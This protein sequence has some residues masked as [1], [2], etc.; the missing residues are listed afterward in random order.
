MKDLSADPDIN[1]CCELS[2][3]HGISCHLEI[4]KDSAAIMMEKHEQQPPP[5]TSELCEWVHSLKFEEIPEEV[6]LRTRY[7]ILDGLAC[8]IIGS[9]L[10]WS[11]VGTRAALSMESTGSC[12]IWG[13]DKVRILF[14]AQGS[15]R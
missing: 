7:L 9:H 2:K 4:W 8:A 13:W 15:L 12:S 1:V 6:L 5:I 3:Q 10:P 14:F 11:E